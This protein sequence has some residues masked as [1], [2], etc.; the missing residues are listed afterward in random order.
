MLAETN[1]LKEYTLGHRALF[2]PFISRIVMM[3]S[4]FKIA[5]CLLWKMKVD[6]VL[7]LWL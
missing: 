4:P 3:Y 2:L 1:Y 7:T 5:F 6:M